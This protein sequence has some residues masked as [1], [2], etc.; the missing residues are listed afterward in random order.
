MTSEETSTKAK[1]LAQKQGFANFFE[2]K[3]DRTSLVVILDASGCEIFR[4]IQDYDPQLDEAIL[5]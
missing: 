2:K 4:T 5:D 1:E 3:Q